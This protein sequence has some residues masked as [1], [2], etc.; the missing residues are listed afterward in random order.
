MNSMEKDK[1]ADNELESWL[2]PEDEYLQ[3]LETFADYL[4]E[5][6]NY[7]EDSSVRSTEE[8]LEFELLFQKVAQE[9][10]IFTKHRYAR[11]KLKGDRNG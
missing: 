5:I 4:Q 3:K 10:W 1:C 6:I 9:R 11:Q 2:L 8:E 7:Y